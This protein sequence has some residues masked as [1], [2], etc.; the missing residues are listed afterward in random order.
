MTRRTLA[1]VAFLSFSA[2]RTTVMAQDYRAWEEYYQELASCDDG[3]G[4]LNESD[5]EQLCDMESH[6]LNIN[7]ITR[8]E[9]EALPFLTERQ[10][11]DICEYVSLHGPVRTLKELLF[12]ESLDRIRRQL[13]ACFIFVGEEPPHRKPTIGERLKM[14]R[15]ELM[16]TLRQPLYKRKGD[17][18]GYL[19]YSQRHSLRYTLTLGSDLRLG[20]AGSQDAGEPFFSSKNSLGYDHYAY[21]IQK[22]NTGRLENIVLGHYYVQFGMGLVANTGFS[23]GKT[24][25]LSTLGRQTASIRP[26]LSRSTAYYL[27]GA[28]ATVRLSEV[29][30]ASVF[31]SYRPIDATL[32][33]DGETIRT[34][35]TTGYHRTPAEME[36]KNNSHAAT[37]GA[38]IAMDAG[39]FHIGATAVYTHYDRDLL[40]QTSATYRQYYPTGNGFINVGTDYAY[41]SHYFSVNGETATDKRGNIATINSVSGTLFDGQLQVMALHRYY[42]HKYTSLY[43]NSF[44]EGGYVR[45]E[46]GAYLGLTW[47]PRL[48]LNLFAYADYAH[49]TWPRYRISHASNAF[50]ALVQPSVTLNRITI[51]ARYRLRLRYRDNDV[52]TALMRYDTHRARLAFTYDYGG[53]WTST[54]QGDYCSTTYKETDHGYMLSQSVSGQWRWLM[55]SGSVNYFHTD[56]YES[57]LY[58]YERSPLHQFAFPMFYGHGLRYALILRA[59]IGKR[60]FVSAKIGVTDY[61]DRA[62]ISSGLQQIDA[63]SM[64]DVDFQVRWKL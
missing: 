47:H 3:T 39:G 23:F 63:S 49:F 10:I 56:S 43:A 48:W 6:P 11:E 57:R 55:L 7:T 26:T 5:Y 15:S 36:K 51:T 29:L 31:A 52:K 62:T 33:K 16:L 34:I 18:N 14:A 53:G 27:Q 38:H 17:S 42:S 45:N 35:L 22:K 24:A 8:E 30:R 41:H 61:F 32:N 54:T 4:T 64:A 40:P 21:Y 1:I 25:I 46:N 20:F 60:L 37:A 28:A 58:A 44:N 13:L 19:G 50:D 12:I 59:D 2:C 9:L